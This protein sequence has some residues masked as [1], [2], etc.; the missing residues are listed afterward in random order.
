MSGVTDGPNA[1]DLGAAVREFLTEE[2]FQ[3]MR[4]SGTEVDVVASGRRPAEGNG[5]GHPQP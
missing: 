1:R 3:L 4:A 5:A 2:R